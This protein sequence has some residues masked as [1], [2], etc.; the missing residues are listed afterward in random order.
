MTNYKQVESKRV[1]IL[2]ILFH[3]LVR[4]WV[5]LSVV[6]WVVKEMRKSY[7]FY[8]GLK[9]LLGILF[10]IVVRGLKIQFF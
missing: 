10:S 3:K 8:L 1:T 4:C 5:A 7:R 9:K 6:I 2:I